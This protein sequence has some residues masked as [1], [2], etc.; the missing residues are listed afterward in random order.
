M[1]PVG[2]HSHNH[3]GQDFEVAAEQFLY[4]DGG[5]ESVTI[6][7]FEFQLDHWV[8]KLEWSK[9]ESE[10]NEIVKSIE[11]LVEVYK[12]HN[13][14]VKLPKLTS[15]K[16]IQAAER[17]E[18]VIGGKHSVDEQFEREV[19]HFKHKL[20]RKLKKSEFDEIVKKAKNLEKKARKT[21]VKRPK[22]ELPSWEKCPCN[23][24]H[25]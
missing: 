22:A 15:W 25:N 16:R 4:L 19:N 20:H 8:T 21:G 23:S 1:V 13:I 5:S 17:G 2:D 12:K 10:Y 11:K 24:N 18:L 7:N 3:A 6:R 9:T 14:R